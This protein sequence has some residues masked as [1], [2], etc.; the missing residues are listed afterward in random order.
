MAEIMLLDSSTIDKIAA[1]EVVERPSSVV[2][3]LVEN[4]MDAGARAVTVEIKEGGCSFIRVTD[5]GGGIDKKQ[6]RK[7]FFRHA[8]SKIRS[9]EDL[10]QVKSLGFRGE[11]LSSIAAVSMVELITKTKEEL[12]GIHY[13]LEGEKE[14]EFSEVGAPE[15]TT[16]IVREL[17]FNTPVRKKFLKSSATEGSYI[18]DLMEH[19]A[20]SRPDVAFQFI[21]NG[22]V[23]FHTS[24][25][26][27]IKEI[28]Y[29]IYGR[30]I[31]KELI[32]FSASAEGLEIQG[33]LG[34]PSVVRSNRNF[35]FFFVNGRY[36]KS[37]LLSKGLEAGY[38]AYLMQHKFPFALLHFTIDP[39]RIDVNVHPSKMEIRFHD[40]PGLYAFLEEQIRGA[41][42]R[43]E[44]IPD[45]TL[46]EKPA[47]P[48]VVQKPAAKEEKTEAP[49]SLQDNRQRI[50]ESL[51]SRPE[52][53]V[54]A[55]P[56]KEPAPAS[57]K[58][59]RTAETRT[60]E[61]GIPRPADK[62]AAPVPEEKSTAA[63]RIVGGDTAGSAGGKVHPP[64]TR[65]EA[66]QP[67][68]TRRLSQMLRE[69]EGVYQVQETRQ[70]ELF[71]EK[72]LTKE[73]VQS[74]RILGQVF[75]T[76]WLAQYEDKL[77]FIDQH[78]AHEKVK[79]EALVS[80]MKNGAVDSQ[81]LT[82]PLVLNLSAR[83]AHLLERYASYFAELGFEIED[84][85]GNAFTVRSVPCDLY[86]HYE[87]DFLEAILDE[88]E[89]E[90]PHGAPAV[91]AEKL[92]SMAC[93]SA[94]KGNH[95]MTC[96]EMEALL[97]Q[98]LKLENPYHCPHG[99]PTIITMSKYELERKFK[100]IV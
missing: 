1:G 76:Y 49:S 26:G 82:P 55:P 58:E 23:R 93:K 28:L 53:K 11:A 98:L 41:L 86:G 13:R 5:N 65:P 27:D 19:M 67:F 64:R 95:T 29:R 81:M 22:Q 35:E 85:G 33:F 80:K 59:T 46:E 31:I 40:Q 91:I 71:E 97:D 44:M 74:Y 21:M 88:L 84:F 43:R 2:K 25:N 14:R 48:A 63:Q 6:V 61:S 36:I 7:A 32:P 47:R 39:D 54:S 12:T 38:K 69:E 8:T 60:A 10:Y 94:V 30:E 78:A 9:V 83:E 87:K 72:L 77:L 45:V 92:A 100:R 37:P 57:E 90:P 75:D 56:E 34:S 18:S 96:R 42:R 89:E 15:G 62:M 52:D 99:R 4:A 16:I 66:P 70:M 20:L 3:E 17:F 50:E 68:E 51:I 73:A 79:Y 24:G